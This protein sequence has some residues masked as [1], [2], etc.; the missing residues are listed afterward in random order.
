MIIAHYQ[1]SY[2]KPSKGFQNCFIRINEFINHYN[3]VNFV[4]QKEIL[5]Q[6]I[7][8]NMTLIIQNITQ[9]AKKTIKSR[10]K[11]LQKP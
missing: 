4:S 7:Q 10:F 3:S 9:C 8:E 1:N 11:M 2:S 6:Q 5:I